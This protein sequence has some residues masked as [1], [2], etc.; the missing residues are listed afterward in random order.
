MLINVGRFVQYLSRLVW[1]NLES[2]KNLRDTVA[3]LKIIE[4]AFSTFR[5]C[6]LLAASH[7]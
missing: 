6:E 4:S 2:R 5:K 7:F 1:H 3:R